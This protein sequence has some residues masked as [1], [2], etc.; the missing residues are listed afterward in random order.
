MHLAGAAFHLIRRDETFSGKSGNFCRPI[1]LNVNATD[2]E[3]EMDDDFPLKTAVDR[4][5]TVHLATHDDVAAADPRRCSLE[6]YLSGKWQAGESDP[7]ELT[8]SGLSYLD[9]LGSE[10]W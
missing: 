2:L 7:E 3:F 8:C 10:N 6:R 5:W 9:R 1:E 4:A